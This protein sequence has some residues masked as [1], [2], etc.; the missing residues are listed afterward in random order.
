[1]GIALL[2]M[3]YPRGDKVRVNTDSVKLAARVGAEL[4]ADIIKCRILEM[5]TLFAQVVQGCPV[6][7]VV[8]AGER[9]A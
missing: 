2:A 1:M 3:M 5:P 6:T 7:R 9:K 4:G 8:I